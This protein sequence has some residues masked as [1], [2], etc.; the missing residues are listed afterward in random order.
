MDY[1]V[2]KSVWYLFPKSPIVTSQA[3]DVIATALNYVKRKFSQNTM[4]YTWIDRELNAD[5]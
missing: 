2:S 4:I 5:Q 3:N 1:K